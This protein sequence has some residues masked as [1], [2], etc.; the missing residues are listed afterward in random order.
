MTTNNLVGFFLG[1]KKFKDFTV[2]NNNL[3][4]KYSGVYTRGQLIDFFSEYLGENGLGKNK[5]EAYREIDFFQKEKFNKLTGSAINQLKEKINEIGVLKKENLSEYVQN[6]RKNYAR[7]YESWSEKEKELLSKALKYTNNLEILSQ[8]FQRGMGSIESL[9]Q[10]LIY[11]SSHD[12]DM[13]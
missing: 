8:C 13:N 5:Y 10:K 6:S 9:G 7:A 4:R 11:E 1:A 3:Y 2:V 12:V